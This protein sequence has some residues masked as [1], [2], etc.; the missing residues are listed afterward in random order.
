MEGLFRGA[1]NINL[2]EKGRLAVPAKYRQEL[3]ESCEGKLIMT[4]DHIDP[5][6]LLYPIHEWFVIEE[7]LAKLP[8]LNKPARILKRLLM[9]YATD[10]N[11]DKNGRL[12]IPPP[13]REFAKL[14]KQIV[15]IGQGS[16]FEIWDEARWAQSTQEWMQEEINKDELIGDLESLT[17]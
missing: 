11:M 5:C 12:L 1:N 17:F 10:V 15:L 14:D 7:K 6:L 3:V 9:G 2:D 4:V 13:L 8:S 16:K